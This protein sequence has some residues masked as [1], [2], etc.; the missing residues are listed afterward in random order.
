MA[1]SG[2]EGHIFDWPATQPWARV[3][4]PHPRSGFLHVPSY[5]TGD[6]NV[7]RVGNVMRNRSLR[8]QWQMAVP[9]TYRYDPLFLSEALAKAGS[10]VKT[11]RLSPRLDSDLP[12]LSSPP[13]EETSRAPPSI[14]QMPV[15]V[16]L[17]QGR[18]L[19][20]GVGVVDVDTTGHLGPHHPV[21]KV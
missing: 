19:V 6:S 3:G 1:G 11:S 21:H 20:R 17:L 12:S 16:S 13:T 5:V 7:Y 2:E 14:S 8:F 18:L 9:V 15:D 10:L 4:I